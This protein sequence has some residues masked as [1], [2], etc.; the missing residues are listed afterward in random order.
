[1]S[2][3]PALCLIGLLVI[4]IGWLYVYVEARSAAFI[5]NRDL[6]RYRI[7]PKFEVGRDVK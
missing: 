1:M 6:N 5:A 2:W 4:G 7:T 3:Q